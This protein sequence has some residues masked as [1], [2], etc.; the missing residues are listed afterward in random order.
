MDSADTENCAIVGELYDR[1]TRSCTCGLATS[2]A[3]PGII[4]VWF[5]I[6]AYQ[7]I[8]NTYI[9][10]IDIWTCYF[11]G[12]KFDGE[13]C[14]DNRQ[15]KSYVCKKGRCAGRFMAYFIEPYMFTN[16]NFL[17]SYS[18]WFKNLKYCDLLMKPNM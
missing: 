5:L 6:I 9:F 18:I 16:N 13:S 10:I 4:R 8:T 14:S 3:K 2:C 15:C 1:S 12:K 11:V 17:H 7:N